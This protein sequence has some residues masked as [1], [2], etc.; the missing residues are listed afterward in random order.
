[1]TPAL[2]SDYWL[3]LPQDGKWVEVLNSDAESY[4]GSGKGNMGSVEAKGGGAQITLP[5]LSTIMLEYVT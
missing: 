2:R 4:G 3:P 1:M 5:P